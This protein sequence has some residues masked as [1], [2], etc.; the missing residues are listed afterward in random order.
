MKSGKLRKKLELFVGK[1]AVGK[2][3]RGKKMRR[4]KKAPER[5]TLSPTHLQQDRKQE[6]GEF[7]GQLK[8]LLLLLQLLFRFRFRLKL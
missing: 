6:P 7:V 5:C 4:H 3:A 1:M 8:V 2:V